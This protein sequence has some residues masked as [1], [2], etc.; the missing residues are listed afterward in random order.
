MKTL[1]VYGALR[2]SRALSSQIDE[3]V[4]KHV[5]QLLTSNNARDLDKGI[6]LVSR[7]KILF[8]AIQNADAAGGSVGTRG[9]LSGATDSG[10]G[11]ERHPDQ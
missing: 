1:A 2:G 3:R 5:A 4:V 6:K 7:N 11:G 9:V 10:A 8:K